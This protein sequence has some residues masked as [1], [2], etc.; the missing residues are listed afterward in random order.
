MLKLC[1]LIKLNDFN[2][3]KTIQEIYANYSQNLFDTGKGS[4]ETI[5]KAFEYFKESKQHPFVMIRKFQSLLNSPNTK[6]QENQFEKLSQENLF[7]KLAISDCQEYKRLLINLK[8]AID[9]NL[10]AEEILNSKKLCIEQAMSKEEIPTIEYIKTHINEIKEWTE[11]SIIETE[12]SEQE[13]KNILFHKM[14][15]TANGETIFNELMKY[16][17]E[18]LKNEKNPTKIKIYNT[19]L[20]RCFNEVGAATRIPKFISKEKPL[21]FGVVSDFLLKKQ[22]IDYH[23]KLCQ[24]YG[25]HR[26]ALETF[27]VPGKEDWNQV[28]DYIKDSKDFM[29]LGEE[30][31]PKILHSTNDPTKSVEVFNSKH[32]K[33]TDVNNIIKIITNNSSTNDSIQAQIHFLDY[34]IYQLHDETERVHTLLINL[35]LN[36]IKS[37]NEFKRSKDPNYIPISRE[38]K[39]LKE[40]RTGL[41]KILK[42]GDG[43][44]YNSVQILEAITKVDERGLIEE[45]LAVL[46]RRLLTKEAKPQQC[47]DMISSPKITSEV[48]LNFCDSVYDENNE[49]TSSIYTELFFGYCQQRT[50]ENK[51]TIDQMILRLLNEKGEMMNL[52]TIIESIP[53]SFTLQSMQS[54]LKAATLKHINKLRLLKIQNALLRKTIETKKKQKKSLQM[55]KVEV[56]SN[57]P[58][59]I[60]CGKPVLGSYFVVTNDNCVAHI[61]CHANK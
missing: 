37:K 46:K 55:G 11:N 21:L 16:I 50:E 6:G 45:K 36:M 14:T 39:E 47:I 52:Q 28:I 43:K 61:A 18:N 38:S 56:D 25:R 4:P 53:K 22:F 57:N 27:T 42:Y 23:K 59:C 17:K 8:N 32:L 20:I 44:Y 33:P 10:T 24:T 3:E 5:A 19:L 1:N 35:Y 12:K 49:N 40:I 7:E 31:Y 9:N 34:D 2:P 13:I 54:F 30:Y 51:K 58:K 15:T 29:K 60:V 41:V 26:E 48:A